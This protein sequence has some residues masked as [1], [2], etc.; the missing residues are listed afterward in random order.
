[1][2][3]LL[4]KSLETIVFDP[5]PFP[6]FVFHFIDTTLSKNVN[7]D[8]HELSALGLSIFQKM[9]FWLF[10]NSQNHIFQES[11]CLSWIVWNNVVYSNP[12]IRAPTG[13]EDPEILKIEVSELSHKQIEKS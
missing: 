4:Q 12:Q 10:E 1:M 11:F 3:F 6:T 8:R 2:L 13:S 5:H 7:I 9:M